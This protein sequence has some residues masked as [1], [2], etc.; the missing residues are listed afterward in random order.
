VT[1]NAPEPA[2]ER[3][4]PFYC[5]YC[6]EEG[7]RPSGTQAGDWTCTLCARSFALR[8]AGLTLA[9]EPS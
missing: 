8:F 7:L 1:G 6:G 5:P 9:S 2:G 4:V 3:Q